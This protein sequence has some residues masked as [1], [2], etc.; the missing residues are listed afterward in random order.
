MKSTSYA[1]NMMAVEEAKRRGADDAVFLA[2]DDIVLEGPTTNIWWRR[3]DTLH[4]PALELGVL[5]GV[6]REV[7]AEAA[8]TIG[9]ELEEGTYRLDDLLQAD[10]AFTSSSVREVMP[11]VAVD[12]T[13]SARGSRARP[14]GRCKKPSAR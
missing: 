14:R 9:Y 3:G 11:V 5:A 1:L 7:I 12:G 2:R 6:T 10:E 13:R 8:P 4:T